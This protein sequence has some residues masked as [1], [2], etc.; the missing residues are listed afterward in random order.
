MILK[1]KS[2]RVDW[3]EKRN[4]RAIW[5]QI[6]VKTLVCQEYQP[7]GTTIEIETHG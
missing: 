1:L 3:G 5:L 6:S 2:Y 7:F 4:Y